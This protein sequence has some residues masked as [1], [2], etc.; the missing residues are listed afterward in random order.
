MHILIVGAGDIGFQLA[1]RLSVEKYDITMIE[2]DPQKVKRANEQLDA[3]VIEGHGASY[4]TLEKAK[5]GRIDIMAAMT[6]PEPGVAES[7]FHSNA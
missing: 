3:M 7:R 4:D 2:L 6:D 5:L 1:K